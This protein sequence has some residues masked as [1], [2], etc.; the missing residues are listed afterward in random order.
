M[1]HRVIIALTILASACAEDL[2]EALADESSTAAPSTD[3]GAAAGGPQIEHEEQSD[4][5]ILTTIDSTDAMRWIHL[6]LESRAQADVADP[7]NSEAWDLAFQRYDIAINGGISGPGGMEAIEIAD[8]TLDALTTA[9][10]GPW[11]TDAA[12]GDDEDTDPD[13]ALRGW[14]DYDFMTHVLTP[15]PNVFVVRS[16]EGGTFAVAVTGYYD[17]AGTPGWLQLRWKPLP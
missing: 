15:K 5:T 2:G 16:V 11:T 13:R 4:G 3:D 6:D 7:A 9:P 1:H 10:E 12:D 8:T 17:D 14:Y